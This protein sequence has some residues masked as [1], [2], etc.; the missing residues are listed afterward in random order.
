MAKINKISAF[1]A[2]TMALESGKDET[3]KEMKS[4][5][6]DMIGQEIRQDEPYTEYV[7]ERTQKKIFVI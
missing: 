5:L 7:M 1:I 6:S 4:I 3:V 2:F